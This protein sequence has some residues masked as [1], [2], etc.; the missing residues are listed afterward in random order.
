MDESETAN[1]TEPSTMLWE[2]LS[3][4]L[5]RFI[6]G[7]ESGA[8]PEIADFLPAEPPGLRKLALVELVKLDMEHRYEILSVFKEAVTNAGKH[9]GGRHIKV[10]LRYK[11]G[12]LLMMIVDDGRGFIMDNATMLG[13]G[14]SDMR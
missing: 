9:A 7:W 3:A 14:I 5:E 2:R 12:K 1:A 6:D 13:R 4:H 11:K 10:S 8:P